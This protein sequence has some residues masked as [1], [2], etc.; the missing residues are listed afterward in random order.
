M[1]NAKEI[2]FILIELRVRAK[3]QILNRHF[4]SYPSHELITLAMR[5]RKGYLKAWDGGIETI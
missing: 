1:V 3:G 2:V 5:A 4:N